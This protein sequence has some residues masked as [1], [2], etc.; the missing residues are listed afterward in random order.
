MR[1]NLSLIDKLI[2]LALAI[3]VAVLIFTGQL[4]GAVAIALGI[5]AAI[6]VA[7]SVVGTC[8]IYLALKISTRG[9]KESGASQ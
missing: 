8:P 4:S 3:V 1:K 7:T 2:R 6:L 9:K 5:F